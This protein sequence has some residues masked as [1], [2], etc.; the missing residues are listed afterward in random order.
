[1]LDMGFIRDVRKIVSALPL[2]RQSLFFSATM[3]SQTGELAKNLLT[4]PVRVE[5]APQ[6]STLE[7]IKQRVFFV[8]QN[9]KIP[10]LLGL[11]KQQDLKRALVF[12]RTKHR[13]DKV[14]LMLN[15]NRINADAIHGNKSQGQRTKAMSNFKSGHLRV[16]VATDIAARGIDIDDISHVVNFDL[17]NEPESY[18]HRI[19]RTGR[20]GAEGNAYSFCAADERSSL[21]DIERL[22][23]EKIEVMEHQYHSEQ[24]KNA[25]GAAAKPI[26]PNRSK[27]VQRSSGQKSVHRFNPR[28]SHQ[29]DVAGR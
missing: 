21:R 2:K 26:T 4:D 10:L 14:A 3:S 25:V 28:K 1:M 6:A 22:T 16:L 20:M 13:A 9:N 29:F 15:K 27:V 11:L 23:R 5:A 8:D 18:V 19:G 24:A 7:C 17:P 12:T